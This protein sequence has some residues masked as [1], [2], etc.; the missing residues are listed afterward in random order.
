MIKLFYLDIQIY[1]Q[2]NFYRNILNCLFNIHK[3]TFYLFIILLILFRKKI[4]QFYL[5]IMNISKKLNNFSC[6]FL[7]YYTY[8]IKFYAIYQ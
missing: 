6:K 1:F 7:K 4:D 5:L 8:V 3:L 2:I